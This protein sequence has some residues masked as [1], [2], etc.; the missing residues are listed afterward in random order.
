VYPCRPLDGQAYT[1]L[2]GGLQFQFDESASFQ[3]PSQWPSSHKT[4]GKRSVWRDD[5]DFDKSRPDLGH[6]R[7]SDND[8]QAPKQA[9]ELP[10]VGEG[11]IQVSASHAGGLHVRRLVDV[12]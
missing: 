10:W 2:I 8:F 12:G 4:R 7:T 9:G 1:G 3:S 6:P 11:R 5:P